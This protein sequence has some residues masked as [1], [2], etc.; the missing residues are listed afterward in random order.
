MSERQKALQKA[1]KLYRLAKGN[2]NANEAESAMR[3]VRELMKKHNL[4][5]AEVE[6]EPPPRRSP[7]AKQTG[8]DTF[9]STMPPEAKSAVFDA[10]LVMMGHLFKKNFGV[11]LGDI[12]QHLPKDQIDN[13]FAADL[14]ARLNK[15]FP[16]EGPNNKEK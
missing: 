8:I 11:G 1:R 9:W 2:T 6:A 14:I 16:Q 13:R 3:K 10:G 7:P 5:P 12:A 4:S 15:L